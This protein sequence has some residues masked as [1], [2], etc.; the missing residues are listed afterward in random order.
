MTAFPRTCCV[1]Q[2]REPE[3]KLCAYAHAAGTF[4]HAGWAFVDREERAGKARGPVGLWHEA[5]GVSEGSYES[6]HADRPASGLAAAHGRVPP[7]RRGRCE[8]QVRVPVGEGGVTDG[9]R[10]DAGSGAGLPRR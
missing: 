2:Y 4:H 9:V 1:V 10:R 8:G 6:V 5:Y 3:E 7:E